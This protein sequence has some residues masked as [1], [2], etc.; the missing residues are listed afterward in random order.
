[1]SQQ[2][3]RSPLDVSRGRSHAITALLVVLGV[4]ISLAVFFAAFS[5]ERA[6]ISREFSSLAEDRFHA[7]RN[8]VRDST[9]LLQFADNVFLVGPPADSPAFSD[10]VRS[11]ADVVRMDISRQPTVRA[12]TWMPRV[13]RSE[14]AAYEQAAQSIYGPTFQLNE[15]DAPADTE[16]DQQDAAFFP[17]YLCVATIPHH[18][19]R[20]DDPAADVAEWEVM[21]RAR[22]TG[23][24][25]ASA[26]IGLSAD[27]SGSIGYHLFQP[28]YHGDP[29]DIASRRQSIAGFVCVDWDISESVTRALQG[30]PPVGID[31]WISDK[32]GTRSRIICQH[33][34]RLTSPVTVKAGQDASDE[35][36]ATWSTEF[37][38]RQ[39]LLRCFTTPAFWAHRTI[40]QP[41]VLLCG[42]LALTLTVAGFRLRNAFRESAFEQTVATRMVALRR[43]TQQQQNTKQ[44]TKQT[45]PTADLADDRPS[46]T[47]LGLPV[48]T[49]DFE[50]PAAYRG[51]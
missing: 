43:D 40:W 29:K 8:V 25:L 33:A 47:V 51:D 23:V 11:L 16:S 2:Q 45:S 6:S 32:T 49:V 4:A 18:D 27:P 34:S 28:L 13:P 46:A 7:I 22:D 19:Q 42:G 24:I 12:V 3:T 17:R 36:E 37:F 5:W 9:R 38:G 15:P 35:L 48:N 39:L 1:M 20:G 10:Y 31:L 44:R 30:I 21:Q 14:Q 41:W 50:V 26:P